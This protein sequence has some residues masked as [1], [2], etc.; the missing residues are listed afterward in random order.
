MAVGVVVDFNANVARFSAGI[1]KAVAD[2][3]R[4]QSN[5]ARISS[6]ISKMFSALG[7]GLSA[8]AVV[9]YGKSIIDLADEMNDLSQRV[10]ISVKDL[11]TW[12]LATKQSGTTM[13]SLA[14][15]IKGLSGFMFENGA[16]LKAAGINATDANGALIEL[17]DLFSVLPDGIIKSNLAV[18]IFGKSGL[19]MIP[20]LNQGG[21][22][23]AEAR[24][25]AKSYADQLAKLAPKADEFNDRMAELALNI[26]A[27][28][29]N[30]TSHFVPGL[31]GMSEWLND[32]ASGGEKARRAVSWMA[33]KTNSELLGGAAALMKLSGD[34]QN[35]RSSGGKI[36]SPGVDWKAELA[37]GDANIAGIKAVDLIN[38]DAKALSAKAFVGVED[39]ASR[40]N[41]AVAGA[42]NSSAIVKAAEL[43]DQ[44]A[45]L[46]SLF[47]DAGLDAGIYTSALEKLTHM[48]ASSSDEAERLAG[49]LDATPTA[50]LEKARADMQLLAEALE[51]R[52]INEAQFN[53]AAQ[54][55]LGQTSKALDEMTEFAREAAR[56]MQDAMAD[57]FFDAMQGK[58]DNMGAS[59]KATVD[60]M[61]AN[62]VSADLSNR[63]FGGFGSTGEMGGWIGGLMKGVLGTS[64]Y[65]DIAGLAAGVP[66]FAEGTPYVKRTG[67]AV[68]HEGEAVLTKDQN[69]R[70]Y[71]GNI[72]VIVQGN[73]NAPDVRRAAGQGAREA[74]A[75]I[76]GA[77]RYS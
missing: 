71:G 48:T 21:A 31:I 43:A 38:R 37:L 6:N 39:Y 74:L 44:I 30:A 7:V 34:G 17:A 3:N 8:G 22:G 19:E 9:T 42:I 10:G 66:A 12:D 55:R 18:K 64:G 77:Q 45:A 1:D 51:K 49:L 16:A 73:N 41:Q 36:G 35:K 62:A 40:L 72:T 33:E 52:R 59:F 69:R 5:T 27:A 2:L 32:I 67:L 15:G 26:K 56:N 28:G 11:A 47:F 60:R 76:A 61:V 70:G 68:I 63:L 23:L 65:G 54:T 14:K 50:Q 58:F 13:E 75:V 46:D 4:F 20:V 29:M 57:L 25:K 24:D 53:E